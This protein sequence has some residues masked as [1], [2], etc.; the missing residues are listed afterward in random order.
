MSNKIRPI[1]LG[2]SLQAL[3]SKHI[4]QSADIKFANN[5]MASIQKGSNI[6]NG[7]DKIIHT[8]KCGRDLFPRKHLLITDFQTAFNSLDR[9]NILSTIHESYP[10]AFPLI[11]SMYSPVSTL[12]VK[13]EETS[14]PI[15]SQQGSQQGD[16]LGTLAFNA[17]L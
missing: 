11:H 3:A 14:I 17:G 16:V 2:Y 8:V 7:I 12:W 10:T 6:K 4:Q 13:G 5:L 15:P 9:N 1:V